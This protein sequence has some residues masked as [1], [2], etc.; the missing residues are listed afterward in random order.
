ML[1]M[2]QVNGFVLTRQF[3]IRFFRG[4][5]GSEDAED[6][7][8]A[9]GHQSPDRTGLFQLGAGLANFGFHLF[10]HRLQDI[11]DS[12]AEKIQISGSQGLH[13]LFCPGMIR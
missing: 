2:A 7:A 1:R 13:A 9:P 10:R 4:G 5:G 3:F 6:G 12:F 11:S 8:P